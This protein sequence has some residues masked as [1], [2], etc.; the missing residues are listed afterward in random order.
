MQADHKLWGKMGIK[1]AKYYGK[2][3]FCGTFAVLNAVGGNVSS[4]IFELTTGVPFGIRCVD[5]K[6]ERFLTPYRDPNYGLDEA[7]SFWNISCRK[8]VCDVKEEIF[9]YLC[10]DLDVQRKRIV[11]GP[12]NMGKLFYIPLC[13]IYE[14]VDHYIMIR[15]SG[16]KE[17]TVMDSEGYMAIPITY[18]ELYKMWN[19]QGVYEAGGV[20]TYRCLEEGIRVPSPNVMEDHI[21]KQMDTN[22][23]SAEQ[24]GQGS[25]AVM[26]AYSILAQNDIKKWF[27][28]FLYEIEHLIQRK[29]LVYSFCQ[30]VKNGESEI[31]ELLEE[32]IAV[33][34]M[35]YREIEHNGELV[36]GQFQRFAYLEKMIQQQGRRFVL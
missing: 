16:R 19:I 12:L 3:T 14:N 11:L 34:T 6:R 9:D 30:S 1:R 36:K 31:L 35:I 23:R 4:D 2:G 18:D 13:S 5:L 8:I 22:L 24:C 29:M 15:K 20:Y 26:D 28:S 10:Q 21:L 33:L 17:V 25:H 7:I 27:L 32:Q